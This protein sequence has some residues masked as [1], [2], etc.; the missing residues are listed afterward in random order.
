MQCL[1]KEKYDVFRTRLPNLDIRHDKNFTGPK[2]GRK[3]RYKIK[4]WGRFQRLI[5][6]LTSETG[7]K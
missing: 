1:D 3:R 5:D 7:E 2:R 6:K 4:Y